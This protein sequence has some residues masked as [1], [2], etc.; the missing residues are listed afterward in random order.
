MRRGRAA[1]QAPRLALAGHLR[2]LLYR[3]P[4][5]DPAGMKSI[6]AAAT[7]HHLPDARFMGPNRALPTC[8]FRFSVS[9]SGCHTNR[10][11]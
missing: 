10:W 4:C 5:I 11:A 2:L 6:D 3:P 7:L 1:P 8:P 9:A